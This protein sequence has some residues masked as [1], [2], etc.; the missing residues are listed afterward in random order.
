M[1]EC[2]TCQTPL[3]DDARFCIACG[4][5]VTGG[6]T[7][8]VRHR[9]TT[10]ELQERLSRLLDG[11]YVIKGLLG[12]GGMGAVFLADDL[13]LERE[14]AIKVLPPELSRDAKVVARFE[15]EAKT[16]ARLDHPH[17]I[18]IHAVESADGLN[19]FIMKFVA[20][21]SLEA[22]LAEGEMSAAFAVK[23]LVEAASALGHAHTRG[24]VHR[25]VKPANI[26]LDAEGRV[27]LTDFG[28]S[29]PTER[30]AQLTHTGT[31]IG[32]PYYMSPEQAMGLT[33][34]GRADQ[35]SLAVLGYK[36]LTG[37]LPFD[38]DALH[39]ILHRH[40]YDDPEP[41]SRLRDGIP[42]HVER[43][44]STAMAKKPEHRF[45][46]ME[47]FARA[48]EGKPISDGATVRV[49]APPI[50]NVRES[51]GAGRPSAAT[52]RPAPRGRRV[53]VF[54][55]AASILLVAS[56][57]GAFMLDRD[58]APAAVASA[59]TAPRDDSSVPSAPVGQPAVDS[60]PV[61]T[62][63]AV[64]D[65]TAAE[66][67]SPPIPR[68]QVTPRRV[69]SAESRVP[70][71]SKPVTRTVTAPPVEERREAMLSVNSDP[72][73]TVYV[74][75]VEIGDTPV[76]NHPLEVGRK[77]ELRIEREGY[78]TRREIIAVNGPNPIRR[79]YVLEG[80]GQ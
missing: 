34:D 61:T 48:L 37:Q 33:V 45:P 10:A 41:M 51:T 67:P 71:E 56:A 13:S 76:A 64:P 19:F 16:A 49:S 68:R 46:N 52:E 7:G 73:G 44:I 66:E 80:G 63:A 6:A 21:R 43:A 31:V 22:V 20:G 50:V 62:I 53:L 54:G 55:M 75:G 69:P 5:D 8:E 70:R 24:I 74:D 15:Q 32:T 60:T 3:P 2:R 18:P 17:I 4:V 72:Y 27:V 42:A 36:M 39:A 1:M 78:R 11:R 12:A 25:D 40:I 77:Y 35:Y 14:V 79:R 59:D 9:D 30:S 57:A 29:K 38:G 47:A 65:D 23:V 58:A 28:I 26:M